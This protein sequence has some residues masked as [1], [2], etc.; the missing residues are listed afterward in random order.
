MEAEFGRY[1]N[2]VVEKMLDEQNQ[3][4]MHKLLMKSLFEN[5][6]RCLVHRRGG[7]GVCISRVWGPR[8]CPITVGLIPKPVYV[9]KCSLFN[10]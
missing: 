10:K 4:N 7:G 8:L 6:V 9:V 3:N 1:Q 5:K 2:G